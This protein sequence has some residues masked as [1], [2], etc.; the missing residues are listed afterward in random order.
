MFLYFILD[1]WII[2]FCTSLLQQA[3]SMK[4]NE[5][6]F[7]RNILD[8]RLNTLKRF[9]K[10][11]TVSRR[12]PCSKTKY[13]IITEIQWGRT[14][15]QLISLTHGVWFADKFDA[16]L[17]VPK[18]MHNVFETFDTTLLQSIFCYTLEDAPNDAEKVEITSEDMFFGFKVYQNDQWKNSLG[19]FTDSTRIELSRYLL[20]FYS[21]L[22]SSPKKILID[23][24]THL[25]NNYLHGN[26]Q[27]SSVHMRRLEGG[28]SKVMAHVTKPSDFSPQELPMDRAEWKTVLHKW[29]PLCDM[30]Y[31]FVNAVFVLHKRNGSL[32]FV[33]H[34]LHSDVTAYREH[35]A[36]LSSM[37]QKEELKVGYDI[38]YL[39]MFMCINSDFFVLNPRSTFSLQIMAMRLILSLPS[40]PI[41]R[42][43]DIF[44]QK[45][46]E[47]LENAHRNLWITWDSM[48]AAILTTN[49]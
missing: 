33:A 45:V 30:D 19:P 48:V 8:L 49:R 35:H 32:V 10:A 3:E 13:I 18:Y 4:Y 5:T 14:G 16:T 12:K 6:D 7:A 22:W 17:V 40:V 23:A 2:I 31:E 44:L 34:D 25:V 46:P 1:F 15:N 24:A 28:C 20:R 26:F 43:N 47:D 39:D 38:K 11:G 21:S 41:I 37:I 9:A 29:H 36:I 27:Y 42:N